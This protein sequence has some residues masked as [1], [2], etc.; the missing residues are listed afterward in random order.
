[1]VPLGRAAGVRG[2]GSP[3]EG[4]GGPGGWFP[5][6]GPRGSGGTVPPG[7]NKPV[8]AL[9]STAVTKG[10][11]MQTDKTDETPVKLLQLGEADAAVCVDGV[12]AVPQAEGADK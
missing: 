4:R 8:C 5:S 11:H 9:V 10:I 7:R 2:D 3:R 12:C 6:G 1:M